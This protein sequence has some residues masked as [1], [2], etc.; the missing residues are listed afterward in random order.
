MN[1]NLSSYNGLNRL[2]RVIFSYQSSGT[3]KRSGGMVLSST[4]RCRIWPCP[5]VPRCPPPCQSLWPARG[6]IALLCLQQINDVFY[7]RLSQQKQSQAL[8]KA[9]RLSKQFRLQYEA[10]KIKNSTS[11]IPDLSEPQKNTPKI[12]VWLC[13]IP[14][15]S[16]DS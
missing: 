8:S 16:T 9:F 4:G 5:L 10:E 15:R 12:S 2:I 14:D 11:N 7:D 3:S 13:M 6:S 1:L